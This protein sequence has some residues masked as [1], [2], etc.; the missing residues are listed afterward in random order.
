MRLP[1][2]S[3]KLKALA[4]TMLLTVSAGASA[5]TVELSMSPPDLTLAV[6]PNLILTFDDSGSMQVGYVPGIIGDGDPQYGVNGGYI[7][8]AV[9]GAKVCSWYDVDG[10]KM[11]PWN[12]SSVYNTLYFDPSVTYT[13]PKK[14]NGTLMSA[15]SFTSA[16]E[17]GI[18]ANTGGSQTVRNLSN[19]YVV[20]WANGNT[21]KPN[22]IAPA[23]GANPSSVLCVPKVKNVDTAGNTGYMP[24]PFSGSHAFYYT[25]S[26]DATDKVALQTASNYTA[27]DVTLQTA[28]QKQNF[29]NWYSFYRTRN[30]AAKSGVARAFETIPS[31][32]R[33][34]WHRLQS[35]QLANSAVIKSLSD[36]TQRKGFYDFLYASP[37]NA[38]TPTRSATARVAAYFG[39]TNT[40]AV[41]NNPYYDATYKKELTCR[42][43]YELL[44]T[45]GGWKDDPGFSIPDISGAGA[46]I[47]GNQDQTAITLPDGVKYDPT[48]AVAAIFGS[49]PTQGGRP[50]YADVAFYYWASNLRPDFAMN[51]VPYLP[52]KSTGV[53]GTKVTTPI[54]NDPK[55]LPP[56]VYF[57]PAN[58]PATWPHLVQFVVAFGLGGQLNFP[59]DYDALRKG[60]K[61][62]SDWYSKP[63]SEGDDTPPKTDDTW[64]AA[65]N[66][67]GQLFN[68]ANPQQ[69]I[70]QLLAVINSIV[71]RESAPVAGALSTAVLGS[72]AV[73]Y[74]TGFNSTDWSGSVVAKPV[75]DAGNIGAELWSGGS[76]LD[77]RAA[78]GSDTRQILTSIPDSTDPTKLVPAAFTWAQ[79]GAALVAADKTFNTDTYGSDRVAFLRGTRTKEGS[80]L[81]VR[82]SVLGAIINSQ[83]TYVAF[84]ASGYRDDFPATPSGKAAPEMAA[85]KTGALTSSYQAFV[86]AHN[87]RAP[88]LYVGANDGMLHAFDATKATDTYPGTVDV[89]PNPGNERWAYVPN[90]VYP[91]LKGL[92]DLT[93]F[94]FVPT[95]DGTPVVRDVFFASGSTPGWHSILVG[96]LRY[97]GRGVFAL[98][99]TDPTASQTTPGSKV[100]WEFNST[101]AAVTGKGDPS[102]LGYTFGRPNVGRL[103]NGSWVVLVP[104]GYFPDTA[105]CTKMPAA[106][107]TYSSLFV[108]DAQTG[109]LIKEL[110]TPTSV[111]GITDPINSFG[112]TSPVLGDYNGDQIDDVAFAGDLQGY[113]WR[114]DLSDE[115]PD[116]WKTNLLFSPD[117]KKLGEQ[118]VTVMPRLFADPTSQSFMVLFGTGKYLSGDDNTITDDTKVQ[119]VYGIRDPGAVDKPPVVFGT[120]NLVQQTMVEVSD[121]RG[122]TTNPVPAVD[123]SSKTVYGW[124]FN[125][126]TTDGAKQSDQGERMV[127]DATA[128]FDTGRAIITTLIPTGNDPCSPERQ[129]AVMVIDAA[130]GGA[131]AGVS[132]GTIGN[133]PGGYG[134]AGA[135]VNNVPTSGSLPAATVLGGGKVVLPGVSLLSDGSTFSVGDAI[136]RRRSW[137]VLNND[138]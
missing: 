1:T 64:H 101:L 84:P 18:A 17:D 128:L 137:R 61:T 35:G 106:C 65:I 90:A 36:A 69:L 95:V 14:S 39:P 75:D 26:G 83:A 129:G 28:A 86:A 138:N 91:S 122:L 111:A 100:L 74:V 46:T 55:S 24:F 4:L 123:A 114:F 80:T 77:L 70:D 20:T 25:F 104:G 88:T 44:V 3:S 118:P 60:T 59:G 71:T 19:K 112:L 133:W 45:D 51:V 109:T 81:R 119:A 27:V 72:D 23:T 29:A 42:R 58:D 98:D 132:F 102:N 126:F 56:E 31:N 134:Q 49:G 115:N 57:N 10:Q 66:S 127:V 107:N 6:A 12:F 5:G 105:D 54:G 22:T 121:V 135:R 33:V 96:N 8:D 110:R 7:T 43:N 82:G 11:H 108:L 30:L 73:T 94:S 16:Y 40:G 13:P 63:N 52:D 131:A 99:V 2:Y 68:A 103:A 53:T 92:T 89:A 21:P 50:G 117:Q 41:A 32:I 93:N 79:A 97:G 120:S 47:A 85:D 125:L 67:R 136:W 15:T 48:S 9:S 87:K 78:S 34:Q 116:N 124:Y 113:V 130:T 76:Q 38:G 62:W 37:A